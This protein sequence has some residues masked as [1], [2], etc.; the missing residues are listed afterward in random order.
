MLAAGLIA[1]A[2]FTSA[3]AAQGVV[4]G[5]VVEDGTR[6][7]VPGAQVVVS[8]TT[9]GALTDAAG[10][11]RITGVQ[12]TQVTVV[13]RRIGYASQT[14]TVTVG[15]T[16]VE[17][18]L[19]ARATSLEEVVVTGTPEAATKREIGNAITTVD[20]AAIQKVAPVQSFQ[21]LLNGRAPNV[22]IAQPS[23]QIGS[24]AKI[25]VRGTSSFDLSQTPLIYIDGVRI[26]NDQAT[27][28]QN[29]AFGS[30]SISRWN[31]FDP[32]D[33]ERVE[34]I[35]GPSAATLY[36]TEA[37]NGVIQIITKKGHAGPPQYEFS[38]SQ[39]MDFIMNPEGRWPTNYG[40]LNGNIVS[41]NYATLNNLYKQHTGDNIFNNGY[42]QKYRGA[43]GG[44]TE[45]FQ[46]YVSA[47]REEDDGV[48]PN[49]NLRR[50]NARL[51]L[52]AQPSDKFKIEGHMT[53]A[54]GR[55]TLAPEAGYGGRVWT[56][57]LMDP[58][59]V[60]TAGVWGFGSYLPWQYDVLNRLYQDLDRFTGSVIVTHQPTSWFTHRLTV[61][62]DQVN[63]MDVELANRVD[64]IPDE[65]GSKVQTNNTDAFRTFDYSATAKFSASS[66]NFATSVG[67]QYYTKR[68][69]YVEA[70]GSVFAAQ[71]LTAISALTT[72]LGNDQDLTENR[73][74]GYYVQEQIG[75]KDRR[76]L[77]L[78]L[79]SD[80][81]SAFG[82]N[83]KRA[84]YP[85]ASLSWVM[86]DEPFWNLRWL[87]SLRLRAAYGET[88]E[89]PDQFAAL[90]TYL[91]VT[92]PGDLPAITALTLG[93]P[94]LGPERGKE[95]EVG[96]DA[97]ML[98]NR[99]G[100]E[101][102]FYNKSTVN[103]ILDAQVAPSVGFGSDRFVNAGE[104][105][106]RGVELVVHGTPIRNDVL[107]WDAS[108]SFSHNDNKIISLGLPGIAAISPGTYQL[109]KPGYPVGAWFLPRIVSAQ[110]DASGTATNILCDDGHGG[111]TDCASAPSVFLGSS[112]PN[113]Q[114]AFSSTFTLW[115]R[116][117][118]YGI[119][120]YQLGQKTLDGNLRIRCYFDLGGQCRDAVDPVHGDPIVVAGMQEGMPFYLIK[121]SGFFRLRQVSATYSLPDDLAAR[122]RATS[123]SI[124]VAGRNLHTWT[125][126]KGLDPENSFISGSRGNS[127]SWD[128]T[129]TPALSSFL[130]SVNLTF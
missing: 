8:G 106:N 74:L 68:Y 117:R 109:D 66:F 70:Y 104:I 48:E 47:T 40:I 36:G 18:V 85:K 19:T 49:N 127:V 118:L 69:E 122:I 101:A 55:T 2:A 22:D 67:A 26:D 103:A 7:P 61:G 42:T 62:A 77:T 102:T 28:P 72:G 129:A 34:V 27:G 5:R 4:G 35:K 15:D 105:R 65:L 119:V 115:Q 43:V 14:K 88:G 31:D 90:R 64:S 107:T 23:G 16:T 130:V 108:V 39:G 97:G 56:T 78:A 60:D 3:A 17:F 91:P 87:P 33:F 54:T 121:N 44:G 86:S 63:T 96:F 94:D 29:Q 120:D 125:S 38:T 83:Y 80:K 92:G 25:H 24:G 41:I 21:E 46:Y 50:T 89:Q 110:V 82:V 99:L 30:S 6:Q 32:E 20:A 81:N 73:T 111:T 53:Y 1:G 52:S 37:S 123:A 45:H 116:L 12:G 57:M 95:F 93:N 98:D 79:R 58:T 113:K 124:T 11:F 9:L 100:V 10:R 114:G 126:Y 75:W 128:Q 13:A 112:V 59:M 84:Y 76:Y 51:N 71:G